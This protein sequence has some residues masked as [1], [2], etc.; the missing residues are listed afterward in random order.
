[1]ADILQQIVGAVFAIGIALAGLFAYF[2]GTNGL[3]DKVL[4]SS[5]VSGER[6]RRVARYTC[7]KPPSPSSRSTW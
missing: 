6:P 5:G 4:T 7:P 2:W 1:M 3:L